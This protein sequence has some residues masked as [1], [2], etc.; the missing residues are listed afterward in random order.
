MAPGKCCSTVLV[1]S[2]VTDEATTAPL[3]YT[4]RN[5]AQGPKKGFLYANDPICRLELE[6]DIRSKPW[7]RHSLSTFLRLTAIAIISLFSHMAKRPRSRPKL[8]IAIVFS[9]FLFLFAISVWFMFPCKHCPERFSALSAR[10]LTQHQTRCQAFLKHEAEASQRRKA[11]A[12]SNKVRRAKLK[13][14][15][16]RLGS[17]APGVSFFVIDKYHS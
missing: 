1:G 11:T 5:G 16:A 17:A 12:A 4:P 7:C 9:L 13:D 10:G 8:R 3:K 2:S 15:K 14:R 6:L